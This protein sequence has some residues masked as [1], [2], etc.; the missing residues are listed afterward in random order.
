MDRQQPPTNQ[1][2]FFST[3]EDALQ[4]S[5]DKSKLIDITIRHRRYIVEP[6]DNYPTF[7]IT[8]WYH[9]EGEWHK[10]FGYYA[11]NSAIAIELLF[12]LIRTS[13]EEDRMGALEQ[14][15]QGNLAK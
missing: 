15:F 9:K 1:S 10:E 7:L 12:T 6:V 14:K 5:G 11:Y 8:E 13:M 4:K 2:D 3:F